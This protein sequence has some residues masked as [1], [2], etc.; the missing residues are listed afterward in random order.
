MSKDL[1]VRLYKT[2]PRYGIDM[3]QISRHS[4]QYALLAHVVL[5]FFMFSNTVIFSDDQTLNEGGLDSENEF[6]QNLFSPQSQR[7]S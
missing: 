1:V 3:S 5:G 4:M 6:F 2:P 7:L